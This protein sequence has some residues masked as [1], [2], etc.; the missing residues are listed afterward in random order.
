MKE[1]NYLIVL[2]ALLFFIQSVFSQLTYT[3][4][5]IGSGNN[6]IGYICADTGGKEKLD[7][8][9]FKI[10]LSVGGCLN[11]LVIC[12]DKFP[13][14]C[15][16][17]KIV[18]VWGLTKITATPNIAF[19]PNSSGLPSS[20]SLQTTINNFSSKNISSQKIVFYLIDSATKTE[21]QGS[22]QT[23]FISVAANTSIQETQTYSIAS[24]VFSEGKS[25]QAIAELQNL[26]DSNSLDNLFNNVASTSFTIAREKKPITVP[27]NNLILISL[28][29]LTVILIIYFKK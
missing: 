23:K 19:L 16:F 27:E 20:V 29:A 3:L 22:R 26:S 1:F 11:P 17:L 24:P 7:S 8:N 6:F 4:D 25:Y 21:V 9:N 14:V 28:I 2:F 13:E 15:G 5:P 18:D 10:E 12:L